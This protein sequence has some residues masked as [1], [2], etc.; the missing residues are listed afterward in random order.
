MVA[1]YKKCICRSVL[2]RCSLVCTTDV[3]TKAIVFESARLHSG[4]RSDGTTHIVFRSVSV[5]SLGIRRFFRTHSGCLFHPQGVALGM[6]FFRASGLPIIPN[7]PIIKHMLLKYDA[8]T[9]KGCETMRWQY[10]H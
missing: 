8:L 10:G 4:L 7:H 5:L 9:R 3:V 1:S 2:M 6:W